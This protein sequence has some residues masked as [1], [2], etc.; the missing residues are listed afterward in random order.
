[1]RRKRGHL[2]VILKY[3]NKGTGYICE[4]WVLLAEEGSGEHGN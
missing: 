1:V 2:G 3:I 4:S